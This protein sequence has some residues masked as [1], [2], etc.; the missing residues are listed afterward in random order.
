LFAKFESWGAVVVFPEERPL[1]WVLPK[2]EPVVVWFPVRLEPAPVTP[3]VLESTRGST[4][5]ARFESWGPAVVF[6]FPVRLALLPVPGTPPV[7]EC[8]RGSTLFAMFESCGPVVV[9]WFPAKP[10]FPV[11]ISPPV[12]VPPIPESIVLDPEVWPVPVVFLALLRWLP[13]PESPPVCPVVVP[14]V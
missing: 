2:P 1:C 6:W 3:P 5:F 9:F 13:S 4:L 14:V 12:C 8:T 10:E 11:P 7:V